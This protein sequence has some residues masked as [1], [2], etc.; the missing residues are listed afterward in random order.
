MGAAAGYLVSGGV[1]WSLRYLAALI[2]VFTAS[3]LLRDRPV[4]ERGG[5]MPAA[6]GAVMA[7]TGALSAFDKL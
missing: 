6:A 1:G 3:F 2:M 4:L 5:T 7:L